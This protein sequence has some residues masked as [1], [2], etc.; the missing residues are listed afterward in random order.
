MED[1]NLT[2]QTLI[3]QLKFEQQLDHFNALIDN[4][5]FHQKEAFIFQQEGF[6]LKEIADLT[7][8]EQETIKS[9][10]RYAKKYIR[11]HLE[12]NR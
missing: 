6:T 11:T 4:L 5:P 2:T 7:D 12:T 1:H 10:L 9:R 3:E 8:E